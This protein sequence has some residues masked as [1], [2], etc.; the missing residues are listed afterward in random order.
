MLNTAVL[1]NTDPSLGTKIGPKK[2]SGNLGSSFLGAVLLDRAVLTRDQAWEPRLANKAVP[3]PGALTRALYG[4]L[5][6]LRRLVYL[7]RWVLEGAYHIYI[8]NYNYVCVYIYISLSLSLSLS[9]SPLSLSLSLSFSLSLS[10]SLSVSMYIYIYIH[11]YICI[12]TFIMYTFIYLCLSL[13]LSLSLC[14]SLSCSPGGSLAAG[15]NELWQKKGLVHR[16]CKPCARNMLA[17][18]DME[19]RLTEPRQA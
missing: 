2:L 6:A 17:T 11:T 19:C 12:Y 13:S 9:L 3:G 10:L 8:Y 5:L 4:R 14:L 18:R 15:S 7:L 16:I 1:I